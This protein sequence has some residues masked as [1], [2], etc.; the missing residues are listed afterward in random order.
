MAKDLKFYSC[1]DKDFIIEV[2]VPEEGCQVSCCGEEMKLIEPNTTDAAGEKHV[3]V[4]EVSGNKVVVKVGSV[5]HPMEEKHHISFIYLVTEKT[6]QRVD[7]PHDGKPE[8]EFVLAEDDKAICAYEYCNLH[9][10]WK[11]EA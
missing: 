8:A 4:I 6:V 1:S 2:V 10:L 11:A 7:L 5:P 9:G 3:P